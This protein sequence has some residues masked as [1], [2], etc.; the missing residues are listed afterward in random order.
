[1]CLTRG[2]EGGTC[3]FWLPPRPLCGRKAQVSSVECLVN[4]VTCV[5]VSP[6]HR[7]VDSFNLLFLFTRPHI[8][9]DPSSM[10]VAFVLPRRRVSPSLFDPPDGFKIWGAASSYASSTSTLERSSPLSSSW[11]ET[12]DRKIA[13]PGF[14]YP[15]PVWTGSLQRHLPRSAESE[16]PGGIAE[17]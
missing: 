16:I 9:T 5:V 11:S 17:A 13:S 8:S 4:F 1:M 2:I 12:L 14:F 3:F 7:E 15:L 10:G 6:F